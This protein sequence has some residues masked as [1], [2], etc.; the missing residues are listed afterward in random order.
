MEILDVTQIEPR[1]KHPSIF[2]KFDEM[3]EG[4]SFI[5]HNDHDPKPLYYQLIA[6]RGEVFDWK[7]LEEG[8]QIWEIQI[9]KLNL[10]EKPTT[11]GELVA[12]DYRKAE[13]FG[14]FG[15]DFCCGGKKTLKEACK[16][17]G[18]DE[19]EVKNELD[20]LENRKKDNQNDFNSW[21]LDFLADYIINIHHKYVK[22]SVTMLFEYSDK[23]ANRHGKN[24]PEVIKIARLFGEIANEFKSHMYKEENI[25]FPYIKKLAIAKRENG[26]IETSAFGTVENPINMMMTEHENVGELMDEVH[27]L[28]NN[29]TPPADACSSYKVLYSKLNEFEQDLHKHVHL[30]NNILFPKAIKLEDELLK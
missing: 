19:N 13:V 28:S 20:K 12:E 6:E 21:D 23:V 25:L 29:F 7:Y 15:L 16:K 11:I 4:A 22:N 17:Q 30:E 5:I 14:K 1:L 8:P 18:V 26:N 10:G 2:K 27:A 9:T 3:A 24:H